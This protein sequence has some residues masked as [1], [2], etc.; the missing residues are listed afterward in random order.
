MDCGDHPNS[1]LSFI[2]HDRESR[3]HVLVI[4][5]LTPNPL[6]NYRVGLP[7]PGVWKEVL[8]SDAGTYG[9]SNL[10]NAGG[11]TAERFAVHNQQHSALFTLP[12][13]SVSVFAAAGPV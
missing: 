8:N 4:L 10:G 6:S 7:I 9:G 5:N 13:L 12:P 2:R 1:V 11:V 3:R